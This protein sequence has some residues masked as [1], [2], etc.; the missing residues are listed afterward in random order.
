MLV[1]N[2]AHQQGIVMAMAIARDYL[3]LAP[4]ERKKTLLLAGSNQERLAITQ[5][6]REGLK[7]E[8][9]LG[10][11]LTVKRLKARDLTETQ[12]GYAHHVRTAICPPK[13]SP[14][15]WASLIE[16]AVPET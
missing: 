5:L 11:S 9:T 1:E 15:I 13:N 8:G 14:S 7:A 12:A 10:Q 6:V 2:V 3:A 16:S 4:D